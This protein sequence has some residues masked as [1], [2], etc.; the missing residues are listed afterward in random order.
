[1]IGLAFLC[2]VD[3]AWRDIYAD[4]IRTALRQL[5]R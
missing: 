1:V 2:N 5:N 4:H 3:K